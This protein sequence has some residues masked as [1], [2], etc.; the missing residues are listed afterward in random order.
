MAGFG[1]DGMFDGQ[2]PHALFDKPKTGRK[3]AGRVMQISS[4]R[5][6]AMARG[7]RRDGF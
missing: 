7:N 6:L 4:G 2:V 1:T 3:L 5:H